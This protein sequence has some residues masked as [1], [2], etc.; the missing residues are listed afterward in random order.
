MKRIISIP[1]LFFFGLVPIF[2][3][4][5]LVKDEQSININVGYIY[6]DLYVNTLCYLSAIFF[7]LIGIN[8][9]SVLIA[10]KKLKK[11]L[12]ITHIVFQLL[13]FIPFLFILLTAT[14]SGEI[15]ANNQQTLELFSI[16]ILV[17]FLLFLASILIHLINFSLSMFL[18][19]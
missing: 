19:K 11:G 17:G 12:T 1:H 9:F 15:D 14:K 13:S 7:S 18:K 3:I 4:L 5:G 6:F 10:G 2:I 8:Y 16:I